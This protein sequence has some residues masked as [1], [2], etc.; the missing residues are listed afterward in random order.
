[1]AAQKFGDFGVATLLRET[2]SVLP[3]LVW[4]ANR[5]AASKMLTI[6]K[7]HFAAAVISGE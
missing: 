2:V 6:P 5:R 7:C 1:M 4:R 3:S